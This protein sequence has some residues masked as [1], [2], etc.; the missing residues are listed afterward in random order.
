MLWRGRLR[1]D[2]LHQTLDGHGVGRG[3]TVFEHEILGRSWQ[4]IGLERLAPQSVLGGNAFDC[5]GLTLKTL[6]SSMY[7]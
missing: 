2:Q 7:R 3:A 6:C 4:L 5:I 1:A